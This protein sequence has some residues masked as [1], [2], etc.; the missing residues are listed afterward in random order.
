MCR[1]CF[2]GLLGPVFLVRAVTSEQHTRVQAPLRGRKEGECS[3]EAHS[4]GRREAAGT[5]SSGRCPLLGVTRVAHSLPGAAS[6]GPHVCASSPETQL[7]P[8]GG[9][10]CPG[11]AGGVA[12]SL[13]SQMRWEDLQ[14]EEASFCSAGKSSSHALLSYLTEEIWERKGRQSGKGLREWHVLPW[15]CVAWWQWP[16]GVLW[17]PSVCRPSRS[18]VPAF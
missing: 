2:A 11:E 14:R 17:S 6:S 7:E 18:A 9:S 12:H 8:A 3:Q 15:G 5:G 4:A 13:V 1:G 10:Q 16:V